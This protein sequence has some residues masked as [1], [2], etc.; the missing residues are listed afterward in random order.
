MA[1]QGLTTRKSPTA[2]A[3]SLERLVRRVTSEC[4][5]PEGQTAHRR[6][7]DGRCRRERLT[8][9]DDVRG[10]KPRPRSELEQTCPHKQSR[11]AERLTNPSSATGRAK[12][13]AEYGKDVAALPVRWS[14]WL[15]DGTLRADLDPQSALL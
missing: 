8:E 11:K 14:A 1:T 13:S 10:E 9:A 7:N 12:T 3:R 5:T 4:W 2:M 6:G 15:G